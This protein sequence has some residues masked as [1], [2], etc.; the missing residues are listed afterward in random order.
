M[1]FYYLIPLILQPNRCFRSKVEVCT[2]DSSWA[3]TSWDPGHMESYTFSCW[4]CLQDPGE[5][6]FVYRELHSIVIGHL[7]YIILSFLNSMSLC[8]PA[9]YFWYYVDLDEHKF[10]TSA[11]LFSWY[12]GLYW[13]SGLRYVALTGLGAVIL[14]F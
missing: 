6:C 11:R 10:H 1:W 9:S 14:L 5:L 13:W 12:L 4:K 8:C 2:G 3:K 7:Q